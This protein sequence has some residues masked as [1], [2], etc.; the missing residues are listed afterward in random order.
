MVKE[1][2]Q[3]GRKDDTSGFLD[4]ALELQ[5]VQRFII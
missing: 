4:V 3:E 1:E 2:K 5:F